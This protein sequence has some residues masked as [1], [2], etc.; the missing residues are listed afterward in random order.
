MCPTPESLSVACRHDWHPATSAVVGLYVVAT[1]PA[2]RTVYVRSVM[3][4]ARAVQTRNP[5]H[6]GHAFLMK[7]SR[8]RLMAKG[9]KNPV[10]IRR[11]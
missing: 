5:T 4:M 6:A 9:Y 10:L 7:D 2:A 1:D 11:P 3:I 8:K